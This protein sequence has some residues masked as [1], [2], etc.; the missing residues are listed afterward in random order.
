[1]L[2]VSCLKKLLTPE[3]R[4]NAVKHIVEIFGRRLRG[5]CSL[6]EIS[7]SVFNYK[8]ADRNDGVIRTRL[9][10][11]AQ[12]HRRWG[13]PQLHIQL[14]REGAIINH[15][16]T[17]RLYRLE[18]LMIR[19]RR[20]IKRASALRI[21]PPQAD[22]I[23][24]V[25]AMDFV[26]DALTNNRRIKT[27]PII[28]T[29][30]RESLA[31]EVDTSINAQRV[32]RILNDIALK[33]GLPEIIT[34]DNGPE[35]RSRALDAWA[36]ERGVKLHFITPG[37]PVEN[38]FIESFNDKFRN[39]CLND[40]CFFTILHARDI[41]ERW[42]MEYNQKRGHSSLGWITPEEFYRQEMDKLTTQNHQELKS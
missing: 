35:F 17:E 15:K 39:E 13:C 37:K 5:A 18:G 20:R 16:R 14:R 9:K 11:L 22:R 32:I 25:W 6:I 28:D 36:Y 19:K 4:R 40:N 29:Y 26:W 23:N 38:P 24:H 42:R 3:A 27:F 10:E 7:R 12:E 21:K 31:I 41:I 1:M 34:I 8:P 33:R 30:T 2:E